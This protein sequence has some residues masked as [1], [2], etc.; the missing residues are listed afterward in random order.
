MN[1]V[2]TSKDKLLKTGRNIVK[3]NGWY[4]LSIRSVAD[5]SGVSVGTIYNYFPSKSELISETVESVWH[6]I[7][8][9]S[10]CDFDFEDIMTCISG[11]F[12]RIRWGYKKYP[13]FFTL[14]SLGFMQHNKSG[15]IH[16]MYKTWQHIMCGLSFV[17]RND[18]NIREDAFNENFTH[19]TFVEML[20]SLILA[21]LIRKEYEAEAV[22]EVVRRILY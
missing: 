17:L 4:S 20:F 5:E 13:D 18:K 16:S 10:E 11:M 19:E 8:H 14:H 7:F 12:K 21:S 1:K 15:G 3:Q 9:D 6:D 22:L 2:V